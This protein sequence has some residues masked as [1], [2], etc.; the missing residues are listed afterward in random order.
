MLNKEEYNELTRLKSKSLNGNQTVKEALRF[1]E[2]NNRVSKVL[3]KKPNDKNDTIKKTWSIYD[4]KEK[5]YE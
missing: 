3:N 2:L 5:S 1:Y 4:K